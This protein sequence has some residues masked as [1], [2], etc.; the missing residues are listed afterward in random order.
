MNVQQLT[1]VRKSIR[2]PQFAPFSN[3]LIT[4]P[5]PLGLILTD[6]YLVGNY[7]SSTEGSKSQYSPPQLPMGHG[8]T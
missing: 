5:Y 8:Y 7:N 2:Q 1:L 6:H 4:R 3:I